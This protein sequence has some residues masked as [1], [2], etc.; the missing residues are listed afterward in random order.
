M[1]GKDE[2][3][4]Q[5]TLQQIES[6]IDKTKTAASGT[7][8]LFQASVHEVARHAMKKAFYICLQQ[9]CA[10][11]NRCFSLMEIRFRGKSCKHYD[12]FSD[13]FS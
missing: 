12:D 6:W 4:S 2:P 7:A 11:I 9:E 3:L 10:Q 8:A 13:V 1:I 5:M